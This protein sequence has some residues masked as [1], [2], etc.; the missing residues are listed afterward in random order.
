MSE[1]PSNIRD[2]LARELLAEATPAEQTE[3]EKWL[4]AH[5]GHERM[6]VALRREREFRKHP[7][8]IDLREAKERIWASLN[9]RPVRRSGLSERSLRGGAFLRGTL[10][11]AFSKGSIHPAVRRGL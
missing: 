7:R 11:G 1:L 6:V 5:P 4:S 3:L 8:A 2:L 10:P 9:E